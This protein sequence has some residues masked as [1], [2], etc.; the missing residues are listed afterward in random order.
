MGQQGQIVA[1]ALGDQPV[2][3]DSPIDQPLHDCLGAPLAQAVVVPRGTMVVGVA[4]HQEML[5]L[6]MRFQLQVDRLQGGIRIH[7]QARAV[8]R[9]EDGIHHC[10][11]VASQLRE[12]RAT[13]GIARVL[14]RV[15]GLL[16][17]EIPLK[18]NAVPISIQLGTAIGVCE[19]IQRL[20]LVR[21]VILQVLES[22]PISIPIRVDEPPHV[23]HLPLLDS[24]V[25]PQ[26]SHHPQCSGAGIIVQP[27]PNASGAPHPT[28][29]PKTGARHGFQRPGTPTGGPLHRGLQGH[30]HIVGELVMPRNSKQRAPACPEVA[31]RF[32]ASH[33]PPDID[34]P[35]KLIELLRHRDHAPGRQARGSH[36]KSLCT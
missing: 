3:I 9:E 4:L 20:G 26:P 25:P 27:G 29:Q 17:A 30:R 24:L 5:H 31:V 32:H 12:L 8:L 7:H 19:S 33:P 13:I 28:L 21:T 1:I 11:P 2:A 14:F 36:K 6:R 34:H 23:G 18:R 10:D 35:A 16:G 22:I 15:D